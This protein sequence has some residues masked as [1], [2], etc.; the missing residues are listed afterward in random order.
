MARP[1]WKSRNRDREGYSTPPTIA[2]KSDGNI[3]VATADASQNGP[4]GTLRSF[5]PVSSVGEIVLDSVSETPAA[6]QARVE[7]RIR[8]EF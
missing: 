4:A 1:W 2:F 6:R 5:A 7:A 8:A 3:L